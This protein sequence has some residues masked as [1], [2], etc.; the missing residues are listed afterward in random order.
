[1]RRNYIK[2]VLLAAI[3]IVIATTHL[4]SQP[5]W[6][7]PK[8]SGSN[9]SS[10]LFTDTKN[11][12]IVGE[13]GT[14][15]YTDD[16]GNSWSLNTNTIHN[17]INALFNSGNS[18]F[19]CDGEIYKSYDKGET[20]IKISNSSSYHFTQLTSINDIWYGLITSKTGNRYIGTSNDFGSTWVTWANSIL[21]DDG[22]FVFQNTLVGYYINK[23]GLW[24]TSD[25]AQTWK[26]TKTFTES[27]EYPLLTIQKSG[28][29]NLFLSH[30]TDGVPAVLGQYW[31]SND[32]GNTW[33][34]SYSGIN[35][36]TSVVFINDDEGVVLTKTADDQILPRVMKTYDAGATWEES[37]IFLP[38]EATAVAS[39]LLAKFFI[40]GK[41]G[42]LLRSN[43]NL[44]NFTDLNPDTYSEIMNIEA[45]GVKTFY[46]A[47]SSQGIYKTTDIGKSWY[48]VKPNKEYEK[49][50]FRDSLAGVATSTLNPR[51]YS[52]TFDGG[53]TW[54][55]GNLPQSPQNGVVM[56]LHKLLYFSNQFNLY[57]STDLGS[58]WVSKSLPIAGNTL[59]VVNNDTLTLYSVESSAGKINLYHSI[60]RGTNWMK[61]TST[62]NFPINVI[63]LHTLSS[64]RVYLIH[65]NKND[66]SYSLVSSDDWGTTWTERL[67]KESAFALKCITS[68]KNIIKVYGSHNDQTIAY[69][70]DSIGETWKKSIYNINLGPAF[71]SSNLT[72]TGKSVLFDYNRVCIISEDLI[73]TGLPVSQTKTIYIQIYPNPAHDQVLIKMGEETKSCFVRVEMCNAMGSVVKAIN[74]VTENG[75]CKIDVTD[76]PSGV[77]ALLLKDGQITYSSKVLIMH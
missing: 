54:F 49:I 67:K 30:K 17:D 24:A 52:M 59:K 29:L 39:P 71:S 19:I 15:L 60:D 47:T 36:A 64:G 10:I 12:I 5:E 45:P 65:Q 18:V 73:S 7:S 33:L 42:L 38:F 72:K 44:G 28:H 63:A 32:N 55:D 22:K 3:L 9:F 16:G 23:D 4:F 66:L 1:M 21:P 11:G 26:L 8:L 48:L 57:L 31:R 25:G 14:I 77:Y 35:I 37:A 75:S 56:T 62:F 6:V 2:S 13:C 27:Q 34:L 74:A 69:I 46:M 51:L 43:D 76:L 58:N 20:W 40:A 68:N 70:S 61:N 41:G 50:S 53:S